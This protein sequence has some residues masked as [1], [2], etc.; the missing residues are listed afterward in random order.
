MLHRLAAVV[1]LAAPIVLVPG[2]KRASAAEPAASQTEVV[3]PA[4]PREG[5]I[6]VA[7]AD[8]A[9]PAARSLAHDVY[10][11]VAL[12]PSM[13]EATARVLTGEAPPKDAPA[14]LVEIAE[15]RASITR[16]ESDVVT[17]RL[18]A[19]LGAELH[20]ALVVAV[21]MDGSRPIARV[22]RTSSSAYESIE[23]G[24]TAEIAADGSRSFRFPGAAAS[25]TVLLPGGG[26]AA[27]RVVA[28]APVA[29]ARPAAPSG[30]HDFWKSGWFWGGLGA[31]ATV[32]L[33]VFAISKATSTSSDVTLVGKV[34]P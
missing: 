17:R 4:A 1:L 15:L 27:S 9:G 14:R 2:E 10:R 3:V 16:S 20:V 6:V 29:P 24:A 33:T 28:A 31:A 32:G 19:S 8:A 34:G 13:D 21:T 23:T 7:A 12:R 5:A 11:D 18:L 25:L 26:S 22:L 30:Q